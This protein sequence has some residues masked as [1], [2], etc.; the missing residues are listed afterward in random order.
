MP[1]SFP[2]WMI[3]RFQHSMY[4]ANAEQ[5]TQEVLE[6]V[7]SAQPPLCLVLHRYRRQWMMSIFLRPPRCARPTIC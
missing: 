7:D 2:D 5:F 1:R 4:Y 3:Y 6:L